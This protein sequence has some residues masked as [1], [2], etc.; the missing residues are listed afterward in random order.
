MDKQ[1][2]SDFHL[3][4]LFHINPQFCVFSWV[5]LHFSSKTFIL[6]DIR[7]DFLVKAISTIKASFLC[8]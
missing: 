8:Q 7:T 1:V 3:Y 5:L 6:P 4:F 2:K